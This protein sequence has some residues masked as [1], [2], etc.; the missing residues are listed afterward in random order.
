MLHPQYQVRYQ[1]DQ[2]FFQL[3]QFLDSHFHVR[4]YGNALRIAE[5]KRLL[6][7]CACC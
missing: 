1:E 3:W 2:G 6:S 7:Y 5:P 4:V